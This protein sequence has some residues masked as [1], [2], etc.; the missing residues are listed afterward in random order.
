MGAAVGYRSL[1]QLRSIG[2][3]T[4]SG[5][6]ITNTWFLRSGTAAGGPPAFDSP[7]AGS[8]LDVLL[9]N[10][11]TRYAAQILNRLSVNFVQTSHEIRKIVGWK[12]GAPFYPVIGVTPTLTGTSITVAGVLPTLSPFFASIQGLVGSV[13]ANGTWTASPTNLNTFTINAITAG[14]PWISGGT[15]QQITDSL[16]WK[17]TD[18][19]S[20]AASAAGT[21]AGEALPLFADVSVR[22]IGSTSGKQWQGRN[23]FAPISEADQKQGKLEAAALTAWQTAATAIIASLANGA[24]IGDLRDNMYFY[25]ASFKQS[26]TYAVPFNEFAVGNSTSLVGS[27]FPQPNLGSMVK[28]KPRLTSTISS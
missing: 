21:V 14:D 3:D 28:R 13:A 24:A 7:I 18:L 1:Y 4:K 27:S 5:K 15:V 16:G 22:K 20:F 10:W 23:S 25:N 8:D 6:R 2:S 9:L 26:L 17:F 11:D 12:Y 19:A